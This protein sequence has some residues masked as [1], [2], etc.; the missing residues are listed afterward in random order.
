M[1]LSNDRAQA[2]NCPILDGPP[3]PA[4]ASVGVTQ[5]SSLKTRIP[6]AKRQPRRGLVVMSLAHRRRRSDRHRTFPA[7]K[8]NRHIHS[9][10]THAEILGVQTNNISSAAPSSAAI[11]PG[12]RAT[13]VFGFG[14]N[15]GRPGRKFGGA[16]AA[17]SV[18]PNKALR[19]AA[20]FAAPAGIRGMRS[21]DAYCHRRRQED[22]VLSCGRLLGKLRARRGQCGSPPGPDPA[23]APNCP[24]AHPRLRHSSGSPKNTKSSPNALT[25]QP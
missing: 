12:Q 22:T 11:G 10:V 19:L 3:A 15:V 25:T 2:R 21:S 8:R 18:A 1:P 24:S 13:G 4:P 20:T 9:G 16:A 7:R 17:L 6:L 14:A 23:L 5:T